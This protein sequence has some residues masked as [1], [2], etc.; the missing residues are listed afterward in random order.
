MVEIGFTNYAVVLLLVTGIVTL[1]VDVKAYDREKRKKEKKAAII[2]G[3]FNVAAG[4]LLF[5]TSWVLDQFFW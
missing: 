5:I 2:V 1:Y 3:W 4:G